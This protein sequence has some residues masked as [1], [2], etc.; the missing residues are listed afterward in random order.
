MRLLP[1]FPT[2]RSS[3]LAKIRLSYATVRA[4]F[5]GVI[6]ARETQV[7]ARVGNGTK[8]FSMVKLDDL[9]ARVFLPGRYLPVVAENQRSEEHTS[10]LQSQSNLLVRLPP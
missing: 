2:R 4:P 10:E 9:V 3:D 5:E 1:S 8:L 6:S 7:G